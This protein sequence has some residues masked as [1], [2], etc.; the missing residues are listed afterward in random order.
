[1]S[2]DDY[3]ICPVCKNKGDEPRRI[4]SAVPRTL[5]VVQNV[6]HCD[7]ALLYDCLGCGRFAITKSD[8]EDAR[9]SERL[10]REEGSRTRLSGLLREQAIRPLPPF[11]L[12]FG[13]EPYGPLQRG[14]FALID[15]DELLTRW[16]RTVPERLDRTLCNLATLSPTGGH[17]VELTSDGV[18][19][20]AFGQ[21]LGEA[22]FNVRCLVERGYLDDSASEPR[23]TRVKLTADGWERFE[24]LTKGSSPDNAV[25]VAMWFGVREKDNEGDRTEEEMR[26]VYD[27]GIKLAVEDAGYHAIRVDEVEHNEWI[28][29]QVLGL[30]RLAPFVVADFTGHRNGVYF[31]AGFARGLGKTVIQ[32][33]EEA[34]LDK[35]HFDTRQLNHVL[36]TTPEELR[37]KL[38]HHI[39]GSI[40]PGPYPPT[41]PDS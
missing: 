37:E 2:R 26:R 14:D 29:D 11:W 17:L 36:W 16:P 35:A 24:K 23:A 38:Y 18:V 33:C 31:E 4:P 6:T 19:S 34:D 5:G 10:W 15:V 7:H 27:E 28:M 32:T 40:G 41:S 22:L 25:F 21:T 20:L 3:S 8:S 39:M 30:T 12:R 1:M 9:D 13:T